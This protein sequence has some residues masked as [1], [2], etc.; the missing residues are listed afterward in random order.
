MAKYLRALLAEMT[1]KN[2]WQLA[3][4]AGDACPDRMQR[5][6][7]RTEWDADL[8]RDQLRTY[9]QT[10]LGDP[11]A[12]VVVD[13]TGAIKKGT[14]TVGV[15]RQYSGTAGRVENCQVATFIAYVT[16][17][18]QTLLDRRLYLPAEWC[19]DVERRTTANIP[20]AITFQTKPQQALEMLQAARQAGVPM[21]WV[22]SDAAYGDSTD[23]RAG[24]DALKLGYVLQ[25][26]CS[27]PVW[28]TRP[29]VAVP[30]W[31]G[32]G[33]RPERRQL[34]A[35][36][37]DW[38]TVAAAMETLPD[39]H[40][41][42]LAV[43]EGE[44]G[45]ITYDWARRRVVERVDDLPGHT[46]WLLARR[47]VSD[48]TDIA[49]YLSNAAQTVTLPTLARE[50][51]KRFAVEQCFEEAKDDVGLDESQ[52]RRWHSWHRHVTLTMMAHAWLAVTRAQDATAVPTVSEE[53]E[54]SLK[55]GQSQR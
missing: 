37:P 52:V 26:S 28:C 32:A 2:C 55:R 23:F 7:Y 21:R 5:L 47:S 49:Y 8:A 35:G 42:R 27:T 45:P 36:A 9:I 53:S 41:H 33:R 38:V 39:G 31:L 54:A 10:E 50:A 12:T 15:K 11:D 1:R 24:V 48:P 18:A 30:A 25:V 34:V 13:D 14:C 3:E 20:D 29:A 19:R 17:R 43:V 22:V 16:P 51:S 4:M 40:W 44:K 46:R 6:L